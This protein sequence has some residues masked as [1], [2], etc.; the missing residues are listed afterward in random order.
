V[1]GGRVNQVLGRV[2]EKMM[3][4]NGVDVEIKAIRMKEDDDFTLFL[5]D[6]RSFF[7]N[8]QHGKITVHN[9]L[10][11]RAVDLDTFEEVK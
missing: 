11:N 8:Y 9:N 5:E 4:L 2:K 7:V 6:G 3:G 1:S 10:T